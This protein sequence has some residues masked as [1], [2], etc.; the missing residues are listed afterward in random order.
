MPLWKHCGCPIMPSSSAGTSACRLPRRTAAR[1]PRTAAPTSRSQSA[2]HA[3]SSPDVSSSTSRRPGG[4]SEP[5]NSSIL[6][7]LRRSVGAG[8]ASAA[9][10]S[11]WIQ[12]AAPFLADQ[13]MTGRANGR[14]LAVNGWSTDRRKDSAFGDSPCTCPAANRF[15]RRAADA[16]L[17][18]LDGA[19]A[20]DRH[21]RRRVMT[22]RVARPWRLTSYLPHG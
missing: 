21:A 5:P 7:S 17:L 1:L 12:T 19:A 18:G 9:A 22:R 10:S 3:K 13:P 20:R 11:R 14:T 2:T 8:D 6:N 4:H 16:L 15:T